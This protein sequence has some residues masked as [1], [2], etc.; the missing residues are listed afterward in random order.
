MENYAKILFSVAAYVRPGG[1]TMALPTSP[2]NSW[3]QSL[4]VPSRLFGTGNEDFELYEE[5]GEFVLSIEMPG[6]ERDDIDINWY[7]GRLNVAAERSNE[8]R[9]RKRTYHRA[10]RLPKE[11]DPEE[12]TAE[13]EN[14]V[15]DV[16]LPVV[17]ETTHGRTIEVQ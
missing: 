13:Y 12:I 10:F 9:N 5:E 14:G 4:D 17:D 8:Q 6:F 16:V 1:P 7:E 3:M 15:L 2:A 11:I